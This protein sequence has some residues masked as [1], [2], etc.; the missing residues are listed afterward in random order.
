MRDG[1]RAAELR[2]TQIS[3]DAIIHAM[4]EGAEAEGKS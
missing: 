3:Q 2:G 4:A 1:Q